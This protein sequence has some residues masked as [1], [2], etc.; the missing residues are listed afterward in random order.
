MRK[1]KFSADQYAAAVFA[2]GSHTLIDR[3]DNLWVGTIQNKAFVIKTKFH[4][5]SVQRKQIQSIVF[6]NAPTYD[7]DVVTLLDH[8]V[9][10]GTIRPD[11]ILFKPST[12]SDVLVFPAKTVIALVIAGS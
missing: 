9:L 5:I 6:K 10:K 4:A 11:D 3:D 7:T 1:R 8:T 2:A 12:S